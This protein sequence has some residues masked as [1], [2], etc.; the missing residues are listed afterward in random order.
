MQL[1]LTKGHILF[2][3][4]E[5]K[6]LHKFE[7]YSDESSVN[8][9]VIISDIPLTSYYNKFKNSRRIKSQNFTV[10]DLGNTVIKLPVITN[11]VGHS[12]ELTL[13]LKNNL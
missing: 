7:D 3:F 1:I 10:V 2:N 4:K 13:K 8:N 11:S 5:D 12:C 6:N 9:S